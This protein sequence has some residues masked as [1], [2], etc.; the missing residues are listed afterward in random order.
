VHRLD[1]S[2]VGVGEPPF[3]PAAAPRLPAADW[4]P[5]RLAKAERNYA[6][7]YIRSGLPRLAEIFGPAE[8]AH[9]AAVCSSAR[10]LVYVSSTAVYPRG[11]GAPIDEIYRLLFERNT[12]GRLKMMGDVVT[13]R[14]PGT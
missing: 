2:G 4:P 7:E 6:M 14:R 13:C 12:L 8:A 10:R 1:E 9:L 5:E 3:D 11:T